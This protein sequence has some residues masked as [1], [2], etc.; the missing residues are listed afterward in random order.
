MIL[1]ARQQPPTDVAGY[2]PTATAGDCWYD[3][4]AAQKAVRFF[5]LG[6]TH[7]KGRWAGQAFK[8]E[9]W[10]D[11]FIRTLF[12]WKRKDGS[13]RY[14]TAFLFIPRKNGKSQIAAAIANFVLLCDAEN[15][16]E[17]YCAASD[18]EQAS[19]V[20]KAAASM[21]RKNDIFNSRVKIRESLRRVIY[22]DSFLRAIPANEG[23]SHG[24]NAHLIVGDE[25]HTWP[26][27]DFY[28]T[29]HTSTGA[30]DQPLE[31]YITTAGHDRTSICHEVYQRAK[32]VRD[33]K[34][35][36]Q[37]FLP[38]IFE[39][40]AED[41][42]TDPATW[43]KANPNLGVSIREDYI[44]DE[45]EKAK[46]N[47]AYENTF[48]RLHLNQWTGQDNRWLQMNHW[49]ACEVTR[50]EIEEGTPVYAGLDLSQTRDFTALVLVHPSGTGF[51][52]WG[53]YWLP[54]DRVEQLQ[55]QHNVPLYEWI[56][57]GWVSTCPGRTIEYGAMH[58]H[59]VDVSQRYDLR[60]VGFDPYN[61]HATRIELEDNHGITMV[62]MRQGV[63]T[64]SGPSKQLERAVLEHTLD[65]S[66][67]P[68]MRWM[69]DNVAVKVD[70]NGNIKP[71]KSVQGERR[72]IDGIVALV[73]G[74]GQ[75]DAAEDVAASVYESEWDF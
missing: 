70:E 39:A 54:E 13:R 72:Q 59:I 41:D 11:A 20:F 46:A 23:G 24:F 7:T 19:L 49:D 74:I 52:S 75:A 73:M 25:L 45:C 66:A 26:N 48:R 53:H 44:R 16:A 18:R 47:P 42:W 36:D 9:P 6:L 71:V 12:G 68:V 29:L 31:V 2:D 61:A 30:R 60:A 69:A 8:L 57:D 50:S 1:D 17:C 22:K 14:R 65:H 10:Q 4:D 67:D 34:A 58:Q 63:P 55:N 3:H 35:P 62:E 38:A 64:L 40:E 56:R 15:E 5:E 37:S 21:L 32:S 28:D 51:K 33:G 27:R 43:R